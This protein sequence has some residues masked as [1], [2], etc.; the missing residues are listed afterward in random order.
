MKLSSLTAGSTEM[1]KYHHK[2]MKKLSLFHSYMVNFRIQSYRSATLLSLACQGPS[3]ICLLKK[4]TIWR[5]STKLARKTC[6]SYL[7]FMVSSMPNNKHSPSKQKKRTTSISFKR[8]IRNQL[9]DVQFQYASRT[10]LNLR[11]STKAKNIYPRNL[12]LLLCISIWIMT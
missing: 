8:S 3:S 10:T 12:S 4:S 11:G 6:T 1:E 5:S 7:P 9:K 2:T